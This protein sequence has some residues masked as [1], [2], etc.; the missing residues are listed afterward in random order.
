MAQVLAAVGL[1]VE[2]VVDSA[3]SVVPNG[4]LRGAVVSV[5]CFVASAAPL[6]VGAA[7]GARFLL[8]GLR[9]VRGRFRP[10]FLFFGRSFGRS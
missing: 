5:A 1:L 8:R 9:P 7:A 2:E 6:G 4:F 10:G 3:G